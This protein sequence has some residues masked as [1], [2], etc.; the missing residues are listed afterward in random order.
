MIGTTFNVK[1][2]AFPQ[3]VEVLSVAAEA[4]SF[5]VI[6]DRGLHEALSHESS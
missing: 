5:V 3:T 2:S 1:G 6:L 4:T